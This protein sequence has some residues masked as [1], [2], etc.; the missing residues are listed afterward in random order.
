MPFSENER[1]DCETS[2]LRYT[3]KDFLKA[4]EIKELKSLDDER[5]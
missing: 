1:R 4:H 2:Y 5:L 3:Y